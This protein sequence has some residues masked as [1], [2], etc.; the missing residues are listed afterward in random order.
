VPDAAALAALKG[1]PVLAFAGI[2]DPQKFF[3]TL[4]DAGID[5][6][7]VVA[8]ADHH[9]Y[10]RS[11]ASDLIERAEREGLIIVTTEKDAARLAGQDDVTALLDVAKTLPVTLEVAEKDAFRDW[12][13]G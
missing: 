5:V 13:L 1:K 10:R 4:R 9:R 12:V 6:R 11:E 3:G 8:F 7:A 2:G